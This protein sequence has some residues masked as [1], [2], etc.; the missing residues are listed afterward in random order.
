MP[1]RDQINSWA[2]RALENLYGGWLALTEHQ[3]MLI[4][5]ATGGLDVDAA[6]AREALRVRLG[7]V[8]WA[9]VYAALNSEAQRR[10]ARTAERQ[11]VGE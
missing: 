2:N 1:E 7:D 3:L 10:A 5:D 6:D 8:S 4:I 9:E 11:E